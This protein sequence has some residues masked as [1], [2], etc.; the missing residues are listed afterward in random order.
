M[1][2]T[3]EWS[4]P[5]Y[6]SSRSGPS[7]IQAAAAQGPGIYCWLAVTDRGNLPHY[8]GETGKSV[9]GRHVEHFRAYASGV[10]SVYDSAPFAAGDI[11]VLFQGPLW[12]KDGWRGHQA[13][14][15]NF[16]AYAR[17][18]SLILGAIQVFVAPLDAEQRVRRRVEAS[19]TR[20][21]YAL[22]ES[23][24][25]LFPPGLRMWTRRPDEPVITVSNTGRLPLPGIPTQFEA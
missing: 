3:L 17:H 20:S 25:T 2:I 8:V 23:V 24:L 14:I 19:L 4:G 1:E 13:F 16:E 5:Y 6:F 12:R 10:Y 18:L 7:I 9:A 15:D 22:P 21:I 11:S